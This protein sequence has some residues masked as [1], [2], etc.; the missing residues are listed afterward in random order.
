MSRLALLVAHCLYRA[1]FGAIP[2][3]LAYYRTRPGSISMDSALQ[4]AD[5][6]RILKQ[7]R[8]P[9]PRVPNPKP[10]YA[11]GL[12]T[13]ELASRQFYLACWA[14][15]LELGSG[16]D[17]R[18]LLDILKEDHCPELHPHGVAETLFKAIIVS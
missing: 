3:I 2:K 10:A 12:S 6:L 11:N 4:L 1:R 8:L 14:A 7:G 13:D 16:A 5:G 17:A 18:P 9:D 15:G